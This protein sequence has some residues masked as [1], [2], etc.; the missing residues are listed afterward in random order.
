M[1]IGNQGYLK[2]LYK[3]LEHAQK[4]ALPVVLAIVAGSRGVPGGKCSGFEVGN[5]V[6]VPVDRTGKSEAPDMSV[7]PMTTGCRADVFRCSCRTEFVIY[8]RPQRIFRFGFECC[9]L[10]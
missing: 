3:F 2:L 7:P 1:N 4:V 8:A 5:P 9:C 10:A 6:R